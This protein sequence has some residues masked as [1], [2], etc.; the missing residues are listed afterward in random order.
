MQTKIIHGLEPNLSLPVEDVYYNKEIENDSQKDDDTAYNMLLLVRYATDT[1]LR[2][3]ITYSFIIQISIWLAGVLS[4]LYFNNYLFKLK[5]SDPV[6][7]TLLTTST[8]NVIG[9][10]MIILKNLFPIQTEPPRPQSVLF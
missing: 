6:L 3:H 1:N 9:M 5:L 2:K 10:M 7:I 8:L 4:V